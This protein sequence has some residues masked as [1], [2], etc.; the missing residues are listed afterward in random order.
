MANYNL[1]SITL[2]ADAFSR[3][4]AREGRVFAV[5]GRE[6]TI[7]TVRAFLK[8]VERSN[9]TLFGATF[10]TSAEVPASSLVLGVTR[11]ANASADDFPAALKQG[12]TLGEAGISDDSEATVWGTL[13][14]LT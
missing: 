1:M 6:D 9:D 2:L 11:L 12:I 3:E 7:K 13:L 5:Y 14:R 8:A 10:V 4:E